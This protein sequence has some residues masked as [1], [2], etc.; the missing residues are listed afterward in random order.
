M[1]FLKVDVEFL[2][3]VVPEVAEH[4]DPHQTLHLHMTTPAFKGN[5][6]CHGSR[7]AFPG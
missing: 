5:I 3:L 2:F 4:G 7:M 6:G 1:E